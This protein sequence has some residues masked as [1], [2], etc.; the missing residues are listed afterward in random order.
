[1]RR[2]SLLRLYP[3][4]RAGFGSAES[5]GLT[6]RN[7]DTLVNPAREGGGFCTYWRPV[8]SYSALNSQ[9]S[10]AMAASRYIHTSSAIPAPMEPY[11]TL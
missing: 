11:I 9:P 5:G 4:P 8:R 1:M 6:H 2:S 3:E 10:R 7:N